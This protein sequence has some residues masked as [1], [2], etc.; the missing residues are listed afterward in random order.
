MLS[1]YGQNMKTAGAR[2]VSHCPRSL[3]ANGPLPFCGDRG[4]SLRIGG[5]GRRTYGVGTYPGLHHRHRGPGI[6]FAQRV[7][8]GL[9]RPLSGGLSHV[10]S[11]SSACL[12]IVHCRPTPGTRFPR[13]RAEPSGQ[14]GYRS[15][16]EDHI[17]PRSHTSGA[18]AFQHMDDLADDA[19]LVCPL[20][21]SHVRL[22]AYGN[23]PAPLLANGPTA[24]SFG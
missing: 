1:P 10:W 19:P 14:S 9:R 22:G 23:G 13:C 20:H 12:W 2:E 5:G 6:A 7:P 4:R 18:T 3:I 24:C 8:G 11:R 16:L 21:T 15:S 17:Q